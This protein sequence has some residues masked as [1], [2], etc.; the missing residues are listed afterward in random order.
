M[1]LGG[2]DPAPSATRPR[3]GPNHERNPAARRRGL[4]ADG[5]ASVGVMLERTLTRRSVLEHAGTAAAG[6]TGLGV[7]DRTADGD[8]GEAGRNAP[9][10]NCGRDHV[11]PDLAVVGA[12]REDGDLVVRAGDAITFDASGT[13]STAPVASYAWTVGEESIDGERVHHAFER[14]GVV[15]TVTLA[16]TDE[17]GR[18]A[19]ASV[20]LHVLERDRYNEPPTPVHDVSPARTYDDGYIV[21]VGE[22]VT[23][24]ARETWDEDGD[25]VGY[26]WQFRD[27]TRSGA[28]AE[29]VFRRRGNYR[30]TLSVTDDDGA[31][32][33]VE[34]PVHVTR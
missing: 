23:F 26:E 15:E 9:G 22:P 29:H 8:P 10:E 24:D 20:D 19:S 32:E 3:V 11:D 17:A 21:G 16:V 33:S 34:V 28:V 12:D 2:G 14:G 30:V 31:T 13:E 1:R 27:G 18:S 5:A 6:A 25:V 7:L 4:K